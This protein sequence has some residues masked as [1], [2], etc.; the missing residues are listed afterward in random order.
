MEKVTTQ[1][2]SLENLGVELSIVKEELM[3][4]NGCDKFLNFF[5]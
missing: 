3:K 2:Q 5:K 1:I 4:N